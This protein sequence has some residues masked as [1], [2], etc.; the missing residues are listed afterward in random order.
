MKII[1]F[2]AAISLLCATGATA[3]DV[4]M[5]NT[6]DN[7]YPGTNIICNQYADLLVE[8]SGGEVSVNTFG[9]ETIPPL[10]QLEPLAAGL[11]DVL[12][13]YPAFHTGTTTLL[14][15][16]ESAVADPNSF[17][18]TGG[19][20]LI[21]AHYQTFGVELVSLP[22]GTGIS[23]F[24]RDALNDEGRFEG[25]T[26]RGL[27]QSHAYIEA[28]GGTGVVLPPSEMFSSLER[29]VIDGALFPLTG[30]QGYG[31]AEVANYYITDM[32]FSLPH[33]ILV[34]S[35]FWN[36]LTDAQRANF[37]EA[38]R[39]LE[40]RTPQA[41]VERN[42]AEITLLNEAGMMP[43]VLTEQSRSDYLESLLEASW[44]FSASRSGDVSAELRQNL[45]D[46]GLLLE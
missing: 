16:L 8:A 14:G 41:Y 5:L 18:D 39:A 29:G 4:R 38:A 45:Q 9:P 15:G 6:W 20:D 7:R 19:F 30:A 44:E 10:E 32:P 42:A 26:I 35:S 22:M 17:R 21:N 34:N 23:I 25:R 3:Q 27:P 12:C 2:A 1:N 24:L 28:L 40:E 36:G 37:Q 13:T 43:Q 46:A 11:F 33:L 31:F